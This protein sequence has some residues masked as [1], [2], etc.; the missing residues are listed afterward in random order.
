MFYLVSLEITRVSNI[1]EFKRLF[2]FQEVD[3]IYQELKAELEKLHMCIGD[4]LRPRE[5]YTEIGNPFKMRNLMSQM[6]R[7]TAKAKVHL[8]PLCFV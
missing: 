8:T 6:Y 2:Y 3:R 1:K 4:V 5:E 7:E